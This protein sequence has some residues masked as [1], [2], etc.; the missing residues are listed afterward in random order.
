MDDEV[1]YKSIGHAFRVHTRKGGIVEEGQHTVAIHRITKYER[2][3]QSARHRGIFRTVEKW[4][5]LLCDTLPLGVRFSA[6]RE[7]EQ[8]D[9]EKYHSCVAH[10]WKM[11]LTINVHMI[12]F[13]SALATASLLLFTCSLA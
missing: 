4:R 10:T 11:I 3:A 1:A 6:T 2:I 7:R 13:C 5:T 8:P 12:L 9:H